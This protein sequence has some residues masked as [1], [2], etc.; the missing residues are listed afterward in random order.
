[1][2]PHHW[3]ADV[4]A[5]PLER[6]VDLVLYYRANA[7]VLKEPFVIA[8]S[9]GVGYD[10]RTIGTVWREQ[11][12]LLLGF[13]RLALD[14][15]VPQVRFAPCVLP[16]WELELW[17]RGLRRRLE[18]SARKTLASLP[19]LL[20]SISGMPVSAE[21]SAKLQ[22][23]IEKLESDVRCL[24]LFC[25]SSS[26]VLFPQPRV[27]WEIAEESFFDQSSLPLLYFPPEHQAAVYIPIFFPPVFAVLSGWIAMFKLWRSKRAVRKTEKIE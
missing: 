23:A 17:S 18:A 16:D 6:P 4:T 27:A 26:Q 19:K 22:T 10:W 5:S 12:K 7:T 8:G 24:F 11:L 25:F 1:M 13:P 2:H 3:S 20:D 15:A 21:M 14:P 9:A